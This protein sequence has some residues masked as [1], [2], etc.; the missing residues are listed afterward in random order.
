MNIQIPR[1]I[2]ILGQD[3]SVEVVTRDESLFRGA[4]ES[5]VGSTNHNLQQIKVRGP[6]DLSPMQ[7]IETTLHEGVHALFWLHGLSRFFEHD[8]GAEEDFVKAFSA[9]LLAMMRDNPLLVEL[10][11]ADV[12]RPHGEIV[13]SDPDHAHDGAD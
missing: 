5:T 9:A 13:R 8:H 6:E 7:A 4:P 12:S 10:I 2:R 11:M 3:Y 1:S